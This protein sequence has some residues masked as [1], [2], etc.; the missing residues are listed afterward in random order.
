M[1]LSIKKVQWQPALFDQADAT[2]SRDTLPECV[3]K[4]PFFIHIFKE[5]KFFQQDYF[6][7]SNLPK[8]TVRCVTLSVSHCLTPPTP[9]TQNNLTLQDWDDTTSMSDWNAKINYTCNAGGH[10]A[11]VSNRWKDF[12]E[13]TCQ[14]DNT[15]STPTWPTCVSSKIYK[16]NNDLLWLRFKC[17]LLFSK[18]LP[19]SVRLW[20]SGDQ[21]HYGN[22]CCM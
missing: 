5:Q 15:F 11:F 2:W 6:F 7:H 10:N 22:S 19:K 12:Y 13:L 17:F 9:P 16:K 4:T 3:C 18:I 14:E 21:M 1:T 8:T 20:K